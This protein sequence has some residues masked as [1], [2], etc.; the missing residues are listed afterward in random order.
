MTLKAVVFDIGQTLT[1]YPIPLNRS[2]LY[3]PSFKSVE[4]KL[5][6]TFTDEDYIHFGEVLTKYNTRIN[7]G[8]KEYSSDV[9]FV[10]DEIKDYGQALEIKDLMESLKILYK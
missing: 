3:R 2:K 8:E 9:L 5:G 1:Y 6:L 10:G 7:P 4:E